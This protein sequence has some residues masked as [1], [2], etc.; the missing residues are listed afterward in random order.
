M[1]QAQTQVAASGSGGLAS[2]TLSAAGT[3][4]RRA[5]LPLEGRGL[6]RR[7]ACSSCAR[8]S[9]CLCGHSTSPS[10]RGV[11]ASQASRMRRAGRYGELASACSNQRATVSRRKCRQVDAGAPLAAWRNAVKARAAS[12]GG[13]VKEPPEWASAVGCRCACRQAVGSST[14]TAD[15]VSSMA[16]R[17]SAWPAWGVLH[18]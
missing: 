1:A 8:R 9:A 3:F 7:K 10:A 12:A 15:G 2:W 14:H 11:A 6:M 17:A 16:M 5:G 13:T 18:T 4:A